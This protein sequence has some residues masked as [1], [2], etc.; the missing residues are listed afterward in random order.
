MKTVTRIIIAS[1]LALSAAGPAL[2]A[3][4]DTL[5]EREA[6]TSNVGS[7]DHYVAVKRVQER[8]AAEARAYAPAGASVGEFNDFGIGSQH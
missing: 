4:E 3:E 5:L 6:Y 1:V 8:H 7:L 2:A